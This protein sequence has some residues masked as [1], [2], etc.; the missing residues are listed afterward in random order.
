[1]SYGPWIRLNQHLMHQKNLKKNF[2]E[3]NN[4]I[5][6]SP[7]DK[8]EVDKGF[9]LAKKTFKNIYLSRSIWC[10]QEW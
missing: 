2:M 1:M 4:I 3:K 6:R 9:V 5:V 10:K 7:K 8:S